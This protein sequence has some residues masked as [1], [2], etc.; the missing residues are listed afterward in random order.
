MLIIIVSPVELREHQAHH[1]LIQ[2][3]RK[4]VFY[5]RICH[6]HQTP[7]ALN[8]AFVIRFVVVVVI[9]DQDEADETHSRSILKKTLATS[10]CEMCACVYSYVYMRCVYRCSV[11][12]VLTCLI[13]C[14]AGDGAV[15]ADVV[16]V[17]RA[18]IRFMIVVGR[19]FVPP[20][21][22]PAALRQW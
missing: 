7:Q 11:F 4:F 14:S 2:D 8:Q 13:I 21:L 16:V 6:S 22:G 19:G 5:F 15:A 20:P 12:C 17:R 9:R 1:K 10:G 3:H 18:R